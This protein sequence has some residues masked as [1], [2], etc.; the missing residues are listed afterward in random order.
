MFGL[1]LEYQI[2]NEYL[3]YAPSVVEVSCILCFISLPI[4]LSVAHTA[5]KNGGI[6]VGREKNFVECTIQLLKALHDMAQS[7]QKTETGKQP[8]SLR[9]E[10]NGDREKG[11]Y[12]DQ[13]KES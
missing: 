9:C 13:A 11:I 5:T 7:V 10:I 6:P 8:F 12:D 1:Y 3:S 4:Y 2:F